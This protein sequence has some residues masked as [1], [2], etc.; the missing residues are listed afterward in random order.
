MIILLPVTYV[1]HI[2]FSQ[3]FYLLFMITFITKTFNFTRE[4][5]FICL[6]VASGLGVLLVPFSLPNY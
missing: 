3:F 1:A 5:L 6:F 4:S 2:F